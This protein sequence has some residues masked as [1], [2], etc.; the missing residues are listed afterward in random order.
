MQLCVKG[1]KQRGWSEAI[2]QDEKNSG[3]TKNLS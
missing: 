3:E 1:D 2:K